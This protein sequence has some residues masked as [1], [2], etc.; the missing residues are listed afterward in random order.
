VN[1]LIV[2]DDLA[3]AVAAV[4]ELEKQGH[5]VLQVKTVA[6]ARSILETRRFDGVMLD[7]YLPS[8][9]GGPEA[10]KEEVLALARDIGEGHFAA[11]TELVFIWL[12]AENV[13][14]EGSAIKGCLGRVA[15]ESDSRQISRYF[16]RAIEGYYDSVPAN[17][18]RDQVLVEIQKDELNRLTLVVP[19]WR[20]DESF[21]VS[22]DEIPHW[23]QVALRAAGGRPIYA[24]ARANLR[25]E[26]PAQ[27]DLSG[28]DL[29]PEGDTDEG[30][31]WDG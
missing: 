17:S 24:K 11:N 31:L 3:T 30:T 25:A 7:Q 23:M 19:T 14:E 13:K 1:F 22:K 12:T 5:T 29:L 2:E 6:E 20:P 8:R 9:L 10:E 15:K 21:V 26:R 18:V 27:L 4:E 16:A 28:Y